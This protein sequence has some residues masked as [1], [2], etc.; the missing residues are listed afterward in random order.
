MA[1]NPLMN[2]LQVAFANEKQTHI[3]AGDVEALKVFGAQ[4]GVMPGVI[5]QDPERVEQYFI[6]DVKLFYNE[7]ITAMSSLTGTMATVE[8]KPVELEVPVIP[9]MRTP[10]NLEPA[11]EPVIPAD[12]QMG[13]PGDQVDDVPVQQPRS[14]VKRYELLNKVQLEEECK[15]RGM[16][17]YQG[18]SK[19]WMISKLQHMDK[20]EEDETVVVGGHSE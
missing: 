17:R 9:P 3:G 16:K 13:D 8:V 4:M 11:P 20:V 5:K 18:R 14:T 10:A 6:E 7:I 15:G 2:R 19:P 1:G 12:L